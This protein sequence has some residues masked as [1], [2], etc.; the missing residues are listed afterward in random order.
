MKSAYYKGLKVILA[1]F[2]VSVFY[3]SPVSGQGEASLLDVMKNESRKSCKKNA[4]KT[5][6]AEISLDSFCACYSDEMT[7]LGSLK[8]LGAITQKELDEGKAEALKKCSA[9]D[10]KVQEEKKS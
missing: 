7:K 4:P 10:E 1:T 5:L 8:M 9:P 2:I 3:T 6:P